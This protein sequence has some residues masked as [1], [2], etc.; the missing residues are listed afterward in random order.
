V[1]H[2][3]FVCEGNVCRSPFAERMMQYMLA[4]TPAPRVTV[5]SAGLTVM[6]GMEGWPIADHTAALV[7]KLGADSR[8]HAARTLTAHDLESTALVLTSTRT[9]RTRVVQMLPRVVQHTFT[10]RQL[11]HILSTAFPE[12]PHP[13]ASHASPEHKLRRIAEQL[14]VNAGVS[15]A[16]GEESDVLDP[17]AK[18]AG[19]HVQAAAQMLPSL[20]LLAVWLGGAP[21]DIPARFVLAGATVERSRW[22]RGHAG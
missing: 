4:G 8:G 21:V 3:L 14:H 20:N 7:D 6:E 16:L 13:S 19:A 9:Q 15:A 1:A 18:R 22:R 17:F 5:A 11:G 12:G 2:L 10:I